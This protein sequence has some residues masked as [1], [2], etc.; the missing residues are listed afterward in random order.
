[1]TPDVTR[2]G[3]LGL[4]TPLEVPKARSTHNVS[5]VDGCVVGP[6]LT[7]L[8]AATLFSLFMKAE[9][10]Y[11]GSPLSLPSGSFGSPHSS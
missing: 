7:M 6:R 3:A 9:T 1:M 10:I 2:R 4:A 11:L 8:E 5:D